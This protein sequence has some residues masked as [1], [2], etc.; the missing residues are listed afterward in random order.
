M[1]MCNHDEILDWK[2]YTE[3][4][5]AKFNNSEICNFQTEHWFKTAKQWVDQSIMNFKQYFVMNMSESI[6]VQI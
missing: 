6:K 3:Y 5:H 4:L 1:S 2:Y